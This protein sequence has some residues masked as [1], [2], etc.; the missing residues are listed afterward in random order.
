MG[1]ITDVVNKD[2]FI[3]Y[4]IDADGKRRAVMGIRFVSDYTTLNANYKGEP[5]MFL[6]RN[7]AASPDGKGGDPSVHEGWA[8]YTWDTELTATTAGWRKIAEQESVD[9]PWGIDERVLNLLVR[10]VD[11][12][13]TISSINTTLQSHGESIRINS[14]NITTINT[15]IAALNE[16]KHTHG[17]KTLLD[18]IDLVAGR[19]VIDDE[20]PLT[21][22]YVYNNIVH[23][24][25][26][27]VDPETGTEEVVTDASVIAER[28]AKSSL[29]LQGL[30]IE[31]V[32]T[33]GSVSI[34]RLDASDEGL[35]AKYLNTK[36][37]TTTVETL[38]DMPHEHVGTGLWIPV[39]DDG[40]HVAGH[41][42]L[43]TAS[44]WFDITDQDKG[45]QIAATG[46]MFL[47]SNIEFDP[48]SSSYKVHLKVAL[49][50]IGGPLVDTD[51]DKKYQHG[52]TYL[53]RKWGSDPTSIEDGHIIREMTST[54][55][56]DVVDVVPMINKKP[57]YKLFS[58]TASGASYKTVDA[59]A[60]KM[61][62][63]KD[64][65][66]MSSSKLKL[67]FE[68]GDIVVL[69]HHPEFGCIK[70]EVVGMND[71]LELA[72][73]CVLGKMNYEDAKSWLS[74]FIEFTKYTKSYDSVAVAGK[75]YFVYEDGSY[76][77]LDDIA[78]SDPLPR[79]VIVYEYNTEYSDGIILKASLPN[80]TQVSNMSSPKNLPN[81]KIGEGIDWWTSDT[82]DDK[83]VT[84]NNESGIDPTEVVGVVPVFTIGSSKSK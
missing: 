23:G 39:V 48:R 44:E 34:F 22:N 59:I 25:Y 74:R 45:T 67:Y 53:V 51:T 80:T 6:V 10:K 82:V 58:F 18:K 50:Y 3:W 41:Y 60:P 37:N 8:M 20:V 13:T 30:V 56:E 5:G 24:K 63:W 35:V 27:W 65:I 55:M 69:P 61:L 75:R 31:I 15:A 16:A 2:P 79:N 9:G 71:H 40:V 14:Q 21:G 77:E 7:A 42:Y 32:N 46:A 33:N 1:R 83:V 19:L 68:I 36:Y 26:V 12:N 52:R 17:N 29:A 72:P 11:F 64:I 38:P 47:K 73:M 49:P 4:V 57:H 76:S 84:R 70:C 78:A 81:Y 62:E 54:P 28:F 43:A 66:S